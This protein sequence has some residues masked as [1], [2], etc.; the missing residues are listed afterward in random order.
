MKEVILCKYGELVLKGLNKKSFEAILLGKVKRVLSGLG[1]FDISYAQSVMYIEPVS[2][3]CDIDEAERR[4]TKVFGLVT[5]IRAAK[6]EKSLDEILKVASEYIPDF[7]YGKS[8]FKVVGKRSDKRFPLTSPQLS[9]EVGGAI[10]EVMPS[11]KVDL[12][13]PEI[14]VKVEVRENAAYLHTGGQKGAGGI[15]HGSSGKALLLLSG[16]IDSPVAGY[17][18]AKRGAIVDALHFD[19]FPYTSERATEKVL[20]LAKEVAAY[21]VTIKVKVISLTKIKKGVISL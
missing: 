5:V 21:T 1:K 7:L 19:S 2:D 15:P 9:A 14:T 20:E 3:D 4:I 10:L 11:L 18:I 13:N 6:A 8:S 16:G 12:V 17:M